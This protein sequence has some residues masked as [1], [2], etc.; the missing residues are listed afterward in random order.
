MSTSPEA[1]SLGG[2]GNRF[3][4]GQPIARANSG[5]RVELAVDVYLSAVQAGAPLEF[6]IESGAIGRTTIR[7]FNYLQ[8][9]P[10]EV[11]A[12]V[13]NDTSKTFTV[14]AEEWSAGLPGRARR[15]HCGGG[16]TPA[17]GRGRGERAG[18]AHTGAGLELFT[19]LSSCER[20]EADL[21]FGLYG[22]H[23]YLA[24]LL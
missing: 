8:A 17:Q 5:L 6:K 24:P 23:D 12:T 19:P 18:P 15:V 14:P 22:G 4:I 3:S 13:L 2:N 16:R 20:P 11:N 1:T 10:V 7:L 21:H 9:A